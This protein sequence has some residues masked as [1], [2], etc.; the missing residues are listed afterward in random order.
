MDEL[1]KY[2]NSLP[3]DE[4]ERFAKACG[5]TVGYLRKACS[6]G[7]QLGES[8]CIG[9]ER[10]SGRRIRCEW[11]RPDVDWAYLRNTSAE[12]EAMPDPAAAGVALQASAKDALPAGVA[13]A[14]GATWDGTERR[15]RDASTDLAEHAGA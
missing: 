11:L 14:D 4:R 1:L 9:A 5:T 6:V 2:L 12:V 7:T 15:Q 13:L 3:A 10:E 8:I